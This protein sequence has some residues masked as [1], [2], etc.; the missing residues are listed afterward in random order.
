MSLLPN[1]GPVLEWEVGSRGN[2]NVG[3]LVTTQVSLV[4]NIG[5]VLKLDKGKK[6]IVLDEWGLCCGTKRRSEGRT[7]NNSCWWWVPLLDDLCV[8]M[9]A[10]ILWRLYIVFS[11]PNTRS[12]LAQKAHFRSRS[13]VYIVS[14]LVCDWSTMRWMWSMTSRSLLWIALRIEIGG[15]L[16]EPIRS[17]YLDKK[18][19]YKGV[20]EW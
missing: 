15:V 9:L 12:W 5:P 1:I 3:E 20:T 17:E 10:T 18:K 14:F 8:L 13:S 7:V 6:G 16:F 4:P 19:L 11:Y 2:G